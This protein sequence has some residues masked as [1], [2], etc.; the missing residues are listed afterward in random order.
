MDTLS[1]CAVAYFFSN[2]HRVSSA[3]IART[4]R[5]SSTPRPRCWVLSSTYFWAYA[6]LQLP[7]GIATDRYS[8]RLIMTVGMALAAIGSLVFGLS[9][10]LGVAVAARTLAGAGV[11][12]VYIRL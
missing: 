12:A 2:F 5:P 3:V 1:L 4:C 11:A 10:S 6:G 8:P 7:I 9:S